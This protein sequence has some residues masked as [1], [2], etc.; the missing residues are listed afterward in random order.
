MNTIN[1]KPAINPAEKAQRSTTLMAM[2]RLILSLGGSDAY[3]KWLEALPTDAGLNNAGGLNQH[4]VMAISM[5]DDQYSKMVATFAK[6]MM[7]YI[8]ALAAQ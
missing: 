6:C 2:E 1:S 7:P 3:I 8:E 4:S 5:N